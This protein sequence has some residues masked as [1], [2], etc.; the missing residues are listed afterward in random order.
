MKS[1][2][3]LARLGIAWIIVRY[4]LA[5]ATIDANVSVSL[6][7]LPRSK[8]WVIL[9][10]GSDRR[11]PRQLDAACAVDT[12]SGARADAI[13]LALCS[14]ISG[15]LAILRIPRDVWTELPGIG[16]QKLGWALDYGGASLLVDTV[17]G[18]T[19]C[20]I[21]HYI[22]LEF[23]GFVELVD[24]MGGIDVFLDE[25][26]HDSLADLRLDPGLHGLDGRTALALAR[27]RHH[28]SDDQG[29]KPLGDEVR[30]GRQNILLVEALHCLRA[31]RR[32][33]NVLSRLARVARYAT[34]DDQ[35]GP[36]RFM[37]HLEDAVQAR[38]RTFGLPVEPAR[39]NDLLRS[40]FPPY[41]VNST[42]FLVLREPDATLL[43]GEIFPIA[44]ER[45]DRDPPEEPHTDHV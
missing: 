38:V 40:P 10:V 9:L 5:R 45:L 43:L 30:T 14:P 21:H 17:K 23:E 11:S 36:S 8:S 18:L 1:L 15:D 41:Q 37:Q 7:A 29:P 24:A 39:Q 12:V 2:V 25:P 31:A 19:R 22:E 35:L 20:P 44:E 27:S 34:V 6:A 13:A 33:L 3:R 32:P 26:A 16:Y 42:N 4:V 28:E